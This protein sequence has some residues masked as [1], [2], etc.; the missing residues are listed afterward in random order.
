MSRH[1]IFF[2]LM[3]QTTIGLSQPFG[4]TVYFDPMEK[5]TKR[6]KKSEY[7]SF[8]LKEGIFDY[9]VFQ[10]T[11][12]NSLR[13]K[14]PLSSVNPD[15]ANGKYFFYTINGNVFGE[16]DVINNKREGEWKWYYNN[17]TDHEFYVNGKKE[18]LVFSQ[19]DNGDTLLKR[20]YKNNK[21]QFTHAYERGMRSGFLL[22]GKLA[23]FVIIED[24]WVLNFTAGAEYRF[25][26]YHALGV[27]YYFFRWRYEQEQY[28][29]P[30]DPSYY[31]EYSSWNPRHS[32]LIDYRF[33]LPFSILRKSHMQPYLQ[34]YYR[35]GN[36]RVYHHEK[37]QLD[38]SD[39][40][41]QREKFYDIGFTAGI[42]WGFLPKGRMGIDINA[43]AY[44]RNKTEDIEYYN[45]PGDHMYVYG[46]KSEKW[47]PIFRVNF[48]YYLWKSKR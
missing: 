6:P 23:G 31:E 35:F 8:H 26:K 17:E 5:V 22:R 43:G 44:L 39:I 27:E 46:V 24:I 13:L 32:M 12:T 45:P 4:D 28:N 42:H 29:N 1:L 20:Q 30:N 40:I 34:A 38:S 9:L 19:K 2:I 15:I 36:A 18:N 14:V 41:T 33:Y 10:Y 25:A 21:L 48:F 16:G 3:M 47:M 11:R 37:Y 7:Y